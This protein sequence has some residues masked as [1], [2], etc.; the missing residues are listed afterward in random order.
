[1]ATRL[2]QSGVGSWN[3]PWTE[4]LQPHGGGVGGFAGPPPPPNT[5]SF[6]FETTSFLGKLT[7]PL[8]LI[9][10]PHAP[11]TIPESTILLRGHILTL[12]AGP[13]LRGPH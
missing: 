1:M 3:S 2:K 8:A 12:C 11:S 7:G 13:S 6:G 10:P 5:P 4:Q 9:Q